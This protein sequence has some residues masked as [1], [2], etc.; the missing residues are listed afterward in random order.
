MS[1]GLSH[2]GTCAA[3]SDE[4]D[5]GLHEVQKQERPGSLMTQC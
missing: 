5:E 2:D 1:T 3:R 4:P